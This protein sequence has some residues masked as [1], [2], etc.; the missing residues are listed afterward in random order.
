MIT[1]CIFEWAVPKKCPAY[2]YVLPLVVEHL[3]SR[4]ASYFLSANTGENFGFPF[5][6]ETPFFLLSLIDSSDECSNILFF[7]LTFWNRRSTK[8]RLEFEDTKKNEED[9]AKNQEKDS[10]LLRQIS[11][12][13]AVSGTYTTLWWVYKTAI[14]VF[15][16]FQQ[17]Y[18]FFEFYF[19]LQA[20]YRFGEKC[21]TFCAASLHRTPMKDVRVALTSRQSLK[22]PKKNWLRKQLNS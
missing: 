10:I 19:G 1:T 9:S 22:R 13:S 18:C 14:Q 21:S 5:T 7:R 12:I 2:Y 6:E 15:K 11:Q 3:Y 20:T 8:V 4:A 17:R 16:K